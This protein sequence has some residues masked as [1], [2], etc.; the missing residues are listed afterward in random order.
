[1]TP[2]SEGTFDYDRAGGFVQGPAGDKNRPT[3]TFEPQGDFNPVF[4]FVDSEVSHRDVTQWVRELS[5][6]WR[7]FSTAPKILVFGSG[8]YDVEFPDPDQPRDF[9]NEDIDGFDRTFEIHSNADYSLNDRF[10]PKYRFAVIQA[11]ASSIAILN[12][13][14]G[15]SPFALSVVPVQNRHILGGERTSSRAEFTHF[16]WQMLTSQDNPGT[17]EAGPPPPGS[18]WRHPAPL[19]AT[20]PEL[21]TWKEWFRTNFQRMWRELSANNV[22]RLQTIRFTPIGPEDPNREVVVLFHNTFPLAPWNLPFL[23]PFFVEIMREIIPDPFNVS[24][25]TLS[26]RWVRGFNQ[27]VSGRMP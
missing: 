13:P 26:G 8:Q 25:G 22:D 2:T 19:N 4:V 14:N 6:E 15:P 10:V 27:V 17:S 12:R 3:P 11:R 9:W 7:L 23:R 16:G 24:V 21:E 18:S 5:G 1:M 20:D